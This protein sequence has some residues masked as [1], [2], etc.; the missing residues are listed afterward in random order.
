MILNK[1][2]LVNNI[3]TELSDNSTGQISPYDIRHN[4]LDI[5]DSVHLLTKGKPLDGSNFGTPNTRTVKIG[6]Y[7][8]SKI[9]L[10]GYF[11]I[12]NT[13]VGYGSLKANY[14]GIKNTAIGSH[15]LFCN[16]YGE[17]NVAAGYSA[18]GGNTIGHGNVG[19]G[20]FALNNNKDG[21][22]N[23]AIGHGAGYYLSSN[24]SNKL[25]IGSYNI[26]SDY[27]CNNPLG[28]GLAPLVYGDLL[29]LKLGIAVND[30][31]SD[32]TLQVSGNI[33]SAYD[34]HSNLGSSNYRHRYLYLSSGIYFDSNL[35]IGKQ[36]SSNIQIKGN[37]LPETT[38][39]YNLGSYDKIWSE[40]IFN[41]IYVSGVATINRF[42]SYENCN[43]FCKTINLASSGNISLDGGGANNLYDY[44]NEE[45]PLI[46]QCGYLP[47]ESLL[48]AG[49]N[50]HSSGN[51][52]V[53]VYGFTFAPPNNALSCLQQ[54]IPHSRASWNSNISIHIDSGRHLR[55]DRIIFPSS[56]NIV[57]S[58]GCFGLFSRGSGLF[59]SKSELVS[60]NQHPS[61]YLAGVGDINFYATSGD[62]SEFIF[63]LAVPDSGVTIK[64]RLLTGIKKKSIDSLNNNID[65]LNG[66]E[67]QYIDDANNYVFGPNS[68]RLIIGSYYDTSLPINTITLMKDNN[69]DGIVGITNL[70][71]NSRNIIP[72]TSLNI[73]S[74]NNAIA[75]LSAENQG[76]TISAIQLLG[77]NNCL[78]DG[79][80]LSY[81]N[82]SGLTDLSIYKDSGKT[83]V[84]RIYTNN[85]IG[86][87]TSSGVANEMLT[88]GDSFYN[89]AV[90]SMRTNLTNIF[91]TA[92]YGKI[93]VKDKA[94]DLQAQSLYFLDG[95]G[96]VHDLVVNKFDVTDAR[97]LYTDILGNTFGGLYCPDKRT[98]LTSCARNTAIGSGA[99]FN[100]TTGINNTIFGANS[101]KELTN[102][103]GNCVF[104]FNSATAITSGN[105]NI[106]IGSNSFRNSSPFSSNNIIIG[107]D[108]V[109]NN[110]SNNY[111]FM[112]GN[113]NITLLDGILGPNNAS[114]Y[115]SMPS[116]G[117][118]LLNDNTNTDSLQLRANY[119][120]IID[121][122]GNNY[123]DN[124]LSFRF[125][126]NESGELLLLNHASVPMT[127]TPAYKSPSSPRPYAELNGDIKLRGAIRFSDFTSLESASFLSDISILQSGVAHN[128][129]NI[130]NL[131]GSF[132]EGYVLS[133]INAPIN[134][135]APT[136]GIL[137]LK[138][139]NWAD[140]GQITLVNRDTTS[141]I[142][143]GAYVIA[144]KVNNEF[145]P[146]WISASDTKCQCCR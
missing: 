127:N 1:D 33:V 36:N 26:D 54:D 37:L 15:A 91:A 83:V 130:N 120:E 13:A 41:N 145:R 34:D 146:L 109:G 117:K 143:S 38:N 114:K 55:T 75:R 62:N 9:D 78:E 90:I 28:S 2:V 131:L 95:S 86:L 22:F 113:G 93:Y 110:I 11:S 94:R 3:V 58:S 44:A 123:P 32:G 74:A 69:D 12:D 144:L 140:A 66:F 68:D 134:G 105:A 16:I 53:R 70:S 40:A 57:N 111:R 72:A 60:H 65:K 103:S 142:H 6:E 20:N 87:Y 92:S 64:H 5:I 141:V 106:V 51:G 19:L 133:H 82:G 67:F 119:I 52:Y 8:L 21:N 84:A 97:G 79:A 128:T 48:D 98:D 47:D 138:N 61:G 46:S 136:T 115:L 56:I 80:E 89:D 42:V 24:I 18:L 39:T 104:G 122:G 4:L 35:Y 132:V 63:N 126:G 102:G 30:L 81:L 88:I 76:S 50:I 108:G 7:A 139:Q 99:L 43:Y 31:H 124:N 17:N 107:N 135:N 129:T 73:R 25:I 121:R 49:F 23:I 101:A 59:F 112:V 137:Y 116:G 77:G 71:P 27:I 100:I 45:S 10:A 118:L 85:T 125:I 96:N 29:N 14:Q